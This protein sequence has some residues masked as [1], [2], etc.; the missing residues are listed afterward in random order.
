MTKIFVIIH[1]RCKNII[2]ANSIYR[3]YRDIDHIETKANTSVGQ[4][5]IPETAEHTATVPDTDTAANTA[6]PIPAG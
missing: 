1:S 3:N 6:S 4:K 5:T 2:V